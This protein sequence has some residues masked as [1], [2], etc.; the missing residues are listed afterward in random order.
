MAALLP[1][2]GWEAT[3]LDHF[4][5]PESSRRAVQIGT[6]PGGSCRPGVVIESSS[7]S[8]GGARGS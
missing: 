2:W 5:S 8:V 1:V 3:G 7:S 6:L 4:G